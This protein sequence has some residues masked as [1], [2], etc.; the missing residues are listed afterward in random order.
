MMLWFKLLTFQFCLHLE[1]SQTLYIFLNKLLACLQFLNILD[2]H[3][4]SLNFCESKGYV[5]R[6]FK[7]IPIYFNKA[8]RPFLRL[9][10]RVDSFQ[11]LFCCEIRWENV[12]T[13]WYQDVI[14]LLQRLQTVLS[15]SFLEV[16][17]KTSSPLHTSS[18][19]K[20]MTVL[21]SKWQI[22]ETP[23]NVFV[24]KIFLQSIFI[25]P[26]NLT[27]FCKFPSSN[28]TGCLVRL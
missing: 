27:K 20:L 9:L 16:L 13:K 24:L 3:E 2:F 23:N 25:C 5:R 19:R 26:I 14:Q 15:P 28:S 12:V 4:N 11:Y 18:L 6:K 10:V 7:C 17:L 22:C 21:L 8:I 1:T